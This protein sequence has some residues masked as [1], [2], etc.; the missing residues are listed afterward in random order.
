[1]DSSASQMLTLVT[2]HNVFVQRACNGLMQARRGE[3]SGPRIDDYNDAA[4][5]DARFP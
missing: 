4:I 3:G 1:V 2:P 5:L